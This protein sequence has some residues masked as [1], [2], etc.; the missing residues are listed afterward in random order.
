MTGAPFRGPFESRLTAH[1]L[2][3]T[4]LSPSPSASR[5]NKDSDENKAISPA[6]FQRTGA[7]KPTMADLCGG[8]LHLA[9]GS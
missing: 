1:R 2:V 7:G 9:Q 8:G 3:F 4:S 5:G 6:S